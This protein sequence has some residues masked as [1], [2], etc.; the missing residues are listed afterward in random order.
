MLTFP[1]TITVFAA[2]ALYL[3]WWRAHLERQ[4]RQSWESLIG[5]LQKDSNGRELSAHFLWKEGLS[6][7]PEETWN[8]LGGVRGLWSIYKNARVMMEMAEFASRHAGVDAEILERLRCDAAQIRLGVLTVMVQC[9]L[10]T[11]DENVRMQAFRAASIYT[12]MAARMTELLQAH[13][14]SALPQFVAAM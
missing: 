10:R 1:L 6:A 11:A 2:A 12:G 8:R 14:E 13:A 3:G 5:R 9:A 4:K 7:G